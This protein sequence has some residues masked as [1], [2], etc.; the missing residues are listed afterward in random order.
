MSTQQPVDRYA[1]FL[2]IEV[3]GH[4]GGRAVSTVT[5]TEDHLNPHDTTHGA[6]VFALVVGVS[7]GALAAKRVR[8][9]FETA[10]KR[11]GDAGGWLAGFRSFADP[12]LYVT[13]GW[14]RKLGIELADLVHLQAFHARMSADAGVQAAL[15]AEGLA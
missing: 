8:R 14:A 2:G 3:T 1:Q 7:M 10:D 6:F 15:K 12:Y 5:V 4:G 11:L 9:H 13:I